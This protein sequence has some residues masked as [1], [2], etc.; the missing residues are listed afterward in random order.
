M[1]PCSC[2]LLKQQS[3]LWLLP[4]SYM[5]WI[6][7]STE[8]GFSYKGTNAHMQI[9]HR[10]SWIFFISS[11]IFFFSSSLIFFGRPLWHLLMPLVR[12]ESC[13]TVVR[14]V[15]LGIGLLPASVMVSWIQVQDRPSFP[16][17]TILERFDGNSSP[18]LGR[19]PPAGLGPC[20][21]L[22]AFGGFRTPLV[23]VNDDE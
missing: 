2:M 3:P 12:C 22:G 6:D 8:S 10:T 5:L 14:N 17:C 4:L 9:P 20:G 21:R 7:S 16:A 15:R 13:E 23:M 19:G 11:R 1:K 18:F